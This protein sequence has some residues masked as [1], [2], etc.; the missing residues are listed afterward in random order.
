MF[1]G[2]ECSDL[3]VKH[4]FKEMRQEKSGQF[5]KFSACKKK[6]ASSRK[7]LATG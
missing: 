7:Q 1:L 3:D 4:I 6:R 5:L 2:V